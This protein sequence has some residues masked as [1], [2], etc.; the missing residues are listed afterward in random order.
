MNYIKKWR[1]DRGLTLQAL[2]EAIE[3][4]A[5]AG[6]ISSYESG[7]RDVSLKRLIEIARVLRVAPGKL[8]DGP[9]RF[10]DTDE[11][12][13]MIESAQRE[14]PAGVSLGGYPS[15]V[16]SSLREQLL[17]FLGEPSSAAAASV[18]PSKPR[19]EVAQSRRPTK[20]AAQG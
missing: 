18:A 14:I 11:L 9:S 3:P 15:A 10:P 20:A 12:A 7:K 13:S 4:T 8:L 2:G 5:S 16:A 19:G 1:E 6:T 17:R